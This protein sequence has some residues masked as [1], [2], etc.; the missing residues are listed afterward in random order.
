MKPVIQLERTG[1]G[2][3][4]VAAMAG[5][6]YR[7]AQRTAN[8]LGI[9]ARDPKLWSETDHVRC[10]LKKYRLRPASTEQPFRSWNSLP[11]LALLTIKW[12]REQGRPC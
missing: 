3:A 11:N 2:I 10:L 6:S 7:Q 1:C 12:H 5:V 4:A 8:Q 9:F